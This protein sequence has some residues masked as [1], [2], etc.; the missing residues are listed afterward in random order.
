M[1]VQFDFFKKEHNANFALEYWDYYSTPAKAGVLRYNLAYSYPVKITKTTT[2]EQLLNQIY[3]LERGSVNDYDQY[4]NNYLAIALREKNYK[5]FEDLIEHGCLEPLNYR[6]IFGSNSNH[7]IISLTYSACY[8]QEAKECLIRFLNKS[9]HYLKDAKY[10]C[11]I[12]SMINVRQ[13]LLP[14]NL[15]EIIIQFASGNLQP[16]IID[17]NFRAI[18]EA[19]FDVIQT[20]QHIRQL[21]GLPPS[22]LPIIPTDLMDKVNEIPA[23]TTTHDGSAR[24]GSYL[25][26]RLA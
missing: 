20:Q 6:C 13:Q 25:R 1:L 19:I 8:N 18:E 22:V 14:E 17:I 5:L 16:L 7:P 24:T 15:N 9:Y 3:Q 23:T 4:D 11:K 26:T 12:F 2:I 21:E 10:K